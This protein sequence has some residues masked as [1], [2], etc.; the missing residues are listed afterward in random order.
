[1]VVS[2]NK[3]TQ[4]TKI[5]ILGTPKMV[6]LIWGNCHICQGFASCVNMRA[7]VPELVDLLRFRI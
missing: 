4:I 3:G 5:H 7:E 6:L 2:Q 1:M